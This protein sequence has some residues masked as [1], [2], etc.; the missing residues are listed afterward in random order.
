MNWLADVRMI[1]GGDGAI[2]PTI[3][4]F[5]NRAHAAFAD[6]LDELVEA[7]HI[8]G[9]YELGKFLGDGFRFEYS[10]FKEFGG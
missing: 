9:A 3:E 7:S 1:D 2:K 10:V 5:P 8:A 4:G 6:G